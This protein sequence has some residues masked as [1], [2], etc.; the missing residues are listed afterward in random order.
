MNRKLFR[1]LIKSVKEMGKIRREQDLR[2]ENDKLKKLL[3]EAKH[4][5]E[6]PDYNCFVASSIE[7]ALRK[8]K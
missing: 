2:L 6:G 1:S 5:V 7:I 4:Y 3:A 8:K